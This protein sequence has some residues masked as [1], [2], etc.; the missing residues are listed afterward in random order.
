MLE[1]IDLTKLEIKKFSGAEIRPKYAIQHHA[2]ELQESLPKETD[3]K[4]YRGNCHCGKY[5]FSLRI[6]EL[7]KIRTCNCSICTR[8]CDSPS[9]AVRV[10]LSMTEW[11]PVAFPGRGR[12][13]G[14]RKR[15]RYITFIRIC[16]QSYDAL[17]ES[18]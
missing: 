8:V 3:L 16:R 10:R 13:S 1:D 12:G 6:P 15:R 5:K 18:I 9:N 2:P 4:Q 7:K 11:I 14:R 17:R